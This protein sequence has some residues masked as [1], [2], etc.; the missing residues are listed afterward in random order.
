MLA[1]RI[2]LKTTLGY[3]LSLKLYIAVTTNFRPPVWVL[4]KG[5]SYL[6]H[7]AAIGM[8]ISSLPRLICISSHAVLIVIVHTCNYYLR[9]VFFRNSRC[10][11]YSRV[12]YYL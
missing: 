10:D 12:H 1:S 9:P 11:Y 3:C 6:E 2:K 8:V 7:Q 5:D 4:I